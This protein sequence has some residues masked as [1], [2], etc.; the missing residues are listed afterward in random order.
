VATPH[1]LGH[2]TIKNT[3]HPIPLSRLSRSKTG[4][5]R[6]YSINDCQTIEVTTNFEKRIARSEETSPVLTDRHREPR[7]RAAT[8]KPVLPTGFRPSSMAP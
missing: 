3:V 7:R 1:F 8:Q 6:S 4:G 2:A 5:G